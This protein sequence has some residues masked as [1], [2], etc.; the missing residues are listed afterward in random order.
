MLPSMLGKRFFS[1]LT[2]MNTK[3]LSVRQDEPT[4]IDFPCCYE[5]C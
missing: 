4:E 2:A 1:S 5:H 3:K